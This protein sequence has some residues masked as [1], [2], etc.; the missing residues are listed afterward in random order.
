MGKVTGAVKIDEFVEGETEYA[1][2]AVTF[3]ELEL[4]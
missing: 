1:H 2:K 3:E 4:I